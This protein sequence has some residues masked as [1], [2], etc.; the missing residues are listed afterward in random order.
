MRPACRVALAVALTLGWMSAVAVPA[1]AA[2]PGPQ[3]SPP[4]QSVRLSLQ[5][6]WPADSVSA[7]TLPVQ[8]RIDSGRRFTGDLELRLV[9]RDVLGST[10]TLLEW[11]EPVDIPARGQWTTWLLL[12]AGN[13]ME[14]EASTGAARASLSP[15]GSP[16]GQADAP[17]ALVLSR[18]AQGWE[19]LGQWGLRVVYLT[20]PSD[21]PPWLSAYRAA[22]LVV[23]AADFPVDRLS[24]VQRE[25]L[26]GYLRDGGAVVLPE[27]T[28]Q[29][30]ADLGA[31]LERLAAAS[32]A[33]DP[34][35]PV[36]RVA[37]VPM[38]TVQSARD[39]LT[40]IAGRLGL[41]PVDPQPAQGSVTAP[42]AA[43]DALRAR[44][45]DALGSWPV[46]TPPR[47]VALAA[48][49][50]AVSV[51]Q[52]MAS[53]GR[54]RTRAWLAV[55]AIMLMVAG[56]GAVAGA[57]AFLSRVDRPRALLLV[58]PSGL[59]GGWAAAGAAQDEPL[60]A[61]LLIVFPGLVESHWEVRSA[62]DGAALVPG[63][64]LPSDTG[65]GAIGF[66]VRRLS[67]EGR[68]PAWALRPLDEIRPSDDDGQEAAGAP[69]IAG[70]RAAFYLDATLGD[71]LALASSGRGVVVTPS[72]VVPVAPA[73][74]TASGRVVRV[75]PDT[76]SLVGQVRRTGLSL[77]PTVLRGMLAEALAPASDAASSRLALAAAQVLADAIAPGPEPSSAQESP[78]WIVLYVDEVARPVVEARRPGH[79][80]SPVSTTTLIVAR[81]APV[82][83]GPAEERSSS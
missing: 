63:S 17:L 76:A 39:A 35:W 13:W 64:L 38:E 73:V 37:R 25:A 7:P 3:P 15:G 56:I 23:V 54:L 1:P 82:V 16:R 55:G 8:V 34:G 51:W 47:W 41:A 83:D 20:S 29:A 78:P 79:R 44:L 40:D 46:P 59:R 77:G 31:H 5:P 11:E 50:Y 28:P 67:S 27:R 6:L 10:P 33:A 57:S 14:L 43:E 42:F 9:A 66:H 71:A 70:W 12:P 45:F 53:F 49:T 4:D 62:L 65:A 32:P 58:R 60:R 74:V 30:W 61:E 69:R 21:A 68:G 18:A 24:P 81:L 22:R 75:D 2:P 19:W 52:W 72:G 48:L 36:P 26:A 80:W